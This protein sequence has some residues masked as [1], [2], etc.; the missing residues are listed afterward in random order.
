VTAL[1]ALAQ[2]DKLFF[3]VKE[4]LACDEFP[5]LCARKSPI[6][7]FTTMALRS[8]AF[9]RLST[10]SVL[11]YFFG[12][13]LITSMI[14]VIPLQIELLFL[15][16]IT[17]IIFGHY[18]TLYKTILW[19]LP[20]SI[21]IFVLTFLCYCYGTPVLWKWKF[22]TLT[23]PGLNLSICLSIAFITI[24]CDM[25]TQTRVLTVSSLSSSSSYKLVQR[26]LPQLSL[27]AQ[28][29]LGTIPRLAIQATQLV[30][31]DHRQY[32]S[33]DKEK[34]SLRMMF[35][36]YERIQWLHRL[37]VLL[38]A[39]LATSLNDAALR[40]A[41]LSHLLQQYSSS[42]R[43]PRLAHH[44]SV[45]NLLFILIVL[46]CVI[47]LLSS[48]SCSPFIVSALVCAVFAELPYVFEGCMKLWAFVRA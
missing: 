32:S 20:A 33:S 1:A 10:L 13:F 36:H 48:L 42:T 39:L 30:R 12:L 43:T 16:F 38:Y 46:L 41:T 45:R 29:T 27:I 2:Y 19:S 17:E 35:H 23:Q 9:E 3:F 28:I 24:T 11:F 4:T 6:S 22:I 8:F 14:E 18:T 15:A 7:C 47:F 25:V 34:F 21:V 40:S 37:R 44:S 26:F 5:K 31:L